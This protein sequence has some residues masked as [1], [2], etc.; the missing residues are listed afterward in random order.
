MKSLSTKFAL[1]LGLIVFWPA[2]CWTMQ[3][4]APPDS[5]PTSS[6]CAAQPADSPVTTK[7][8]YVA[9]DGNDSNPGTIDSPWR[10]IH[11]AV[12]SVE[13]GDTVYIRGGVYHESVDI[14]V[15]GSATAGPV[16]FQSYPGEGAIL[17]GGGLTPPTT[18]I[19]GLINIEGESYVTVKGLEIR[20]YQTA[21]ADATPSGIWITGTGSHIQIMNNLVH[22][23]GTTAEAS[24]NA[25][26]IAVYGTESNAALDNVTI[27]GNQVHDLKTGNSE[28][29]TVNGNV[30]NFAINCNVVHDVDNIGIAVMGFEEVASDPAVD[31]ARNG[32]ISR[33]TLYNISTKTNP[34]EKNQYNADGISVD[35]SSQVI[36]EQNLI[37]NVDIGIEIASQ[38]KGH[39]AHDVSARNN[40]VYHANSVG[41][42]I[43]GYARNVGGAD[44]CTIVNNTLFQNDTRNTGSGEFQIQY[45]A[46][47]N[48]FKN[49]I[50]SASSQGL[51]VN[52][53]SKDGPDPADLD[54]NLYFSQ[55]SMS[56][57]EFVWRGKDHEGF[58][59]YQA[60]AGKDRHSKYADQKLLNPEAIDPRIKPTSLP[61]TPDPDSGRTMN[62]N[63]DFAAEY[64]DVTALLENAQPAAFTLRTAPGVS[65][66]AD[67]GF[68]ANVAQLSG[69]DSLAGYAGEL[70]FSVGYDF[71]RV[72]EVESGIPFYFLSA[73]NISTEPGASHLSYRYSSLGDAFMRVAINPL[74][75]LDYQSTL[76]VTAPTGTA[77]VSTGQATLDWN[78]RV[79]HDWWYLHPF[80]EF[81]L[82]NVPSVTPRLEAF[83]ISGLAAQVHLGNTF[84]LGKLGSF[85]TSFYESVPLGNATAYFLSTGDEPSTR[86]NLLSDHGFNG[87]FSKTAGHF[88]FD[89]TYNRSIAHSVDAIY[90]TI[91]YR[92]GHLRGERVQ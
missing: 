68:Y 3:E 46:T 49:N 11:H 30:T 76:T 5:M 28:S 29:V 15:S 85:D 86:F 45:Y 6:V 73:K 75:R 34:A 26:G 65:P 69:H 43:G 4:K 13:A 16:T 39:N 77:N 38:H 80:G 19:R 33:N 59:T 82:G 14:D 40:L 83:R 42:T 12:D 63:L 60:A 89:V 87:D 48:V 8:F 32:T 50:V 35:S 27:S 51:F 47:D 62:R 71:G 55:V 58:A 41:I 2:P 18:D 31:Y 10:T 90:L 78:N 64:Q 37:Y 56:K 23:I 9:V 57:A 53:Y 44:H 54:Y 91:G 72:V 61:V 21:N 1:F 20:N 66:L 84:D 52:D 70:D 36:I 24:G 74:A 22:N 7:A 25:L 67:S 92:I 81:V 79:E 88:A 17:D